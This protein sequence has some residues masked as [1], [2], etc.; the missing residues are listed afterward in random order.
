MR[1]ENWS[2]GPLGPP[3]TWTQ[4]LRTAIEMALCCARPMLVVWGHDHIGFPNDAF[5]ALL[6]PGGGTPIGGPYLRACGALSPAL[7]DALAAAYTGETASV[8]I[9]RRER[10]PYELFCAPLRHRNGAIGG[11][12]CLGLV[13]RRK[14]AGGRR[15]EEAHADALETLEPEHALARR[16]ARLQGALDAAG[17]GI[18][19]WQ[20]AEDVLT[21]DA[22]ACEIL[23]AAAAPTS[24]SM[25]ERGVDSQDLERRRAE[26]AALG[27][28]A[29]PRRFAV[30]F[31]WRRDDGRR[32]WLEQCGEARLEETAAGLPTMIVN[33]TLRDV[34]ERRTSEEA[35]RAASE[36]KDR[37]LATL[38]HELR[39]PLA[40]LRYAAELLSTAGR[41]DLNWSRHVIDRQVAHLSRLIDDLFDI[42]RIT[43]EIMSIE[44]RRV[45]LR[46]VVQTAVE[47][48][49]PAIAQNHQ[50]LIVHL[51]SEPIHVLGDAVRLTQ[52]V[53]NLL[54]NASKF[55]ARDGRIRA[56]ARRR[57]A[58]GAVDVEDTGVGIRADDLPHIFDAFFQGQSDGNR[59][60]GG[61]GI[62]LYLAKRFI[63]LH[64][65]SIE[66]GS[67][68]PGRGSRFGV[69]LPL[70]EP[71][72][73]AGAAGSERTGV[74]IAAAAS[75]RILVV[76]DDPD[77]AD[78]LARLLRL[79]GSEV[80]TA[81]DGLAAVLAAEQFQPQVVLLDLDMPRLDGYEAC[82]RLRRQS[83]ASAACMVA[84]SGWG[85]REDRARTKESGFDSHLVKPVGRAD[86]EA[87]L[88]EW[89]RSKRTGCGLAG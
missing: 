41:D 42:S 2:E 77:S 37:F 51:P 65:G 70:A 4:P 84:L 66:A 80:E 6:Q 21:L 89:R 85:R 5:E 16:A 45:D 7:A 33:G 56:M 46:E 11:A 31:R 64:G 73:R 30:E 35:L 63:E 44:K 9:E 49:R 34:T 17:I 3:D 10:G 74:Q 68:G 78:A 36:H 12:F 62:G 47:T 40:P 69:R 14:A 82:R 18:W 55:T 23:G 83:W 81:Y 71:L 38:A 25:F 27:V 15:R 88:L 24:E 59:M 29:R 86:V 58:E 13:E 60:H 79:M 19:E 76:D 67:E 75:C 43:R 32:V 1:A 26:M 53:V 54:Q 8:A 20:P 28:G 61:L 48:C 52:V 39:N 57:G 22:R 72:E 50:Q 87:L